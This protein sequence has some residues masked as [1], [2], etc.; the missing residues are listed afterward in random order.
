MSRT[1]EI[2]L[3]KNEFWWGGV[4]DDGVNM[5]FGLK[6]YHRNLSGDFAM[7]QATPL[8]ISNKGR[9]V[10]SEQ[11]FTYS[12]KDGV[13]K[14]VSECDDVKFG[15][16][17]G[18]LREVYKFAAN[19]YFP[20]SGDYPDLLLFSAP[21]YNLWI[22]LLYNP[23]QEKV[24]DYAQAV[25][26]HGMEPGVIMID[27]NWQEYYGSW[28]FHPGRFPDP[29]AMADKL[30]SMGFKVMLWTCPFI[31]ADT[32][33]Y[34]YLRDKGYLL[35]DRGGK[36]AIRQ[37]WNGYSSVLDCTN[38]EAVA[39][40]HEQMD[41]LINNYGIDGFKLDAGDPQF[42]EDSD[43]C[44][45]PATKNEHCEA[46]ARIGLKYKLNEYRACWKLAGQPLVQRLRDKNHSWKENGLETLIPNAL[47]QGL[48]G[49]S[50]ICPDMIG[51]GEYL[52]FT[53]NSHNLD[54]EL[55][56]RYAQCSA[57]FPMMQ[58]SAAPWRV[59]DEEHLSYCIE[60][61]KLHTA[62]GDEIVAIVKECAVTG[63][64]IMRHLAYSFPKGGYEK[65]KDQFMLGDEI[66]VAPVIE[67][68]AV[69]RK[70][71]MPEGAWYGD[72]GSF[73]EGP[74]TIII[75]APLSR[76]PWYRKISS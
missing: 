66:L 58:F 10:W 26:N 20:P 61:A 18:D 35:K 5:P 42:Y 33:M 19:N 12:F 3:L 56:V 2:K 60:A 65:V 8:I 49:Y 67:K 53:A 40:Y 72:D 21:Q 55:F 22:E 41:K 76:L 48:A 46:W 34:R 39:W 59:L 44:A 7:N 29:K 15:E 57:L 17:H 74:S 47:A 50:F 43:M 75:D 36:I 11:P 16:G 4:I 23:T 25:L 62:L 70:V 30:H 31:S 51:G 73:I 69:S 32:V 6:N 68:G 45:N 13:L 37:W 27:D 24:I 54:Q 14:I 38:P 71:V 28:D 9:Y 64:P 63:E 52:Q 1:I